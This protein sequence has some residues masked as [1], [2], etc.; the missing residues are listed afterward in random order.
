MKKLIDSDISK[1][2]TSLNMPVVCIDNEYNLYTYDEY[3]SIWNVMKEC[4]KANR[5]VIIFSAFYD[6]DVLNLP[7]CEIA[8]GIPKATV[9]GDPTEG[10][11]VNCF[12]LD[13]LISI[14]EDDGSWGIHTITAYGWGWACQDTEAG[15]KGKG[16]IQQYL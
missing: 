11:I 8:I 15:F 4:E 3:M 9:N 16:Y 12:T 5:P 7:Y 10:D 13:T 14:S 1:F 2:L 6:N